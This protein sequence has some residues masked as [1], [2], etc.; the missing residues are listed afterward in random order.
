MWPFDSRKERE[1]R[2]LLQSFSR[3]L[4]PE[5]IEDL[6]KRPERLRP[7]LQPAMIPY[8][9]LQVRDDD[10]ARVGG[11]LDQ[12]F[13]AVMDAD[14]AIMSVM[15]S[16]VTAAFG[17]PVRVPDDE[18]IAQR[19]KAMARLRGDLGPN[20]RTVFGCADGLYGGVGTRRMSYQALIP[21]FSTPLERLLRL[22]FGAS[23][24]L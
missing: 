9:I 16:V 21:D 6:V 19:D 7:N 12:A 20:V 23:A 18:A 2:T 5:M 8:I 17:M 24:E 4:S 10:L 1:Q 3:Y 11:L 22:E 15:S 14:G 13:E